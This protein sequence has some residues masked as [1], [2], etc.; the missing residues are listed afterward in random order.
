MLSS[1]VEHLPEEKPS[2]DGLKAIAYCPWCEHRFHDL[3][4]SMIAEQPHSQLLHYQCPS[5]G[6]QV[7][8]VL[9]LNGMML[10]SSGVVSDLRP[11]DLKRSIHH[12]ALQADDVIAW[13]TLVSEP[14]QRALK[15]FLGYSL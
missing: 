13:H 4:A 8:A 11:H 2:A 15:Q 6:S 5:C 7:I 1:S 10:T 3:R 14:G 12:S 9:Q